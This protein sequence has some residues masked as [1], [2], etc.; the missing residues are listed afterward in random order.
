MA[1]KGRLSPSTTPYFA[2][3]S[4]KINMLHWSDPGPKNRHEPTSTTLLEPSRPPVQ[5][6]F[7]WPCSLCVPL[8]RLAP[9]PSNHTLTESLP[10]RPNLVGGLLEPQIGIVASH[11][12]NPYLLDGALTDTSDS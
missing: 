12:S 8:A 9:V 1:Q 2:V 11:D 4:R 10:L 6:R 3:F 5:P 7:A